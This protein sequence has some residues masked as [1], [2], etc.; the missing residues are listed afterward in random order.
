LKSQVFYSQ[1]LPV[2]VSQVLLWSFRSSS[3]ARFGF[4]RFEFTADTI[5]FPLTHGIKFLDFSRAQLKRVYT[6]SQF[7]EAEVT[8]QF[9]VF[10]FVLAATKDLRQ[11]AATSRVEVSVAEVTF[12]HWMPPVRRSMRSGLLRG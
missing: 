8:D 5:I 3:F 12:C 11:A 7:L 1:V 9:L 6:V 10:T 2:W 4:A